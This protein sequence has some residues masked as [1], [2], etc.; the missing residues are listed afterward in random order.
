MA[1]SR[2]AGS[3]LVGS[4]LLYMSRRFTLLASLEQDK[5]LHSHK[6]YLNSQMEGQM[7]LIALYLRL[8]KYLAYPRG[9]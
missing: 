3:R 5:L 1:V 8:L 2:T 4:Q 6:R 7:P 9:I